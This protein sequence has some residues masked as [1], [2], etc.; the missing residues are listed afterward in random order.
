MCHGLPCNFSISL[1][2][3]TFF[4]IA[5][6][7]YIVFSW[8]YI[9]FGHEHWISYR[10]S[11]QQ[12]VTFGIWRTKTISVMCRVLRIFSASI[13][14]FYDQWSCIG[15]TVRHRYICWKMRDNY[16]RSTEE[17]ITDF[18]AM[19][20]RNLVTVGMQRRKLI[21]P[22]FILWPSIKS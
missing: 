15:K 21:C 4:R 2:K 12:S 13:L 20:L 17:R 6:I 7:Y 8:A 9:V 19:L 22:Y 18:H 14:W 3:R 16:E 10:L 5:I 1:L 11:Q